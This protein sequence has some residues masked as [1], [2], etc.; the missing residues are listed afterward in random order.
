[1]MDEVDGC[2][3]QRDA[4]GAKGVKGVRYEMQSREEVGWMS[5]SIH[6]RVLNVGGGRGQVRGH[7]VPDFHRLNEGS[8]DPGD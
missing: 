2:I 3:F 1:M 6:A 7:A 5:V 4:K 8:R